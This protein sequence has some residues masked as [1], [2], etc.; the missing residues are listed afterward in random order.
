MVRR[1][2]S[3]AAGSR[4]RGK[5]PSSLAVVA[6]ILAGALVIAGLE[7]AIRW[8]GLDEAVLPA[9][10]RVVARLVDDPRLFASAAAVTVLEIAVGLAAACL[11]GVT[12]GSGMHLSRLLRH[13]TR[14]WL[15]ASQA[16]PTPA[17]APALALWLG[18]SLPT[19]AVVVALV[20]FFPIAVATL[21]GLRSVDPEL[22]DLYRSFDAPRSRRLR[23][24]EL[25]GALPQILSG[26][27]VGA[28]FAVVGAVFGEWVG[29]SDGLGYLMLGAGLD[30]PRV[31]ACVVLLSAIALALVGALTLVERRV[32]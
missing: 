4:A 5:E 8:S 17:L 10:S 12:A 30:T 28:A 22:V 29:S 27:R 13:A 18:Y 23:D 16:V 1:T 2:P 9:P 7:V 3:A 14:P 19:R 20:A 26:V 6:P 32:R 15:I 25:P 11:V 24:V 21:D 31:Y